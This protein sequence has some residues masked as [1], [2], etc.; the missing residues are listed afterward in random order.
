M[1]LFLGLGSFFSKS[2]AKFEKKFL[3]IFALTL[4]SM[5][6]FPFSLRQI[7]NPDLFLDGNQR[8][9]NDFHNSFGFPIF[10]FSFSVK[11]NFFFL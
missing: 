1:D 10:S 7:L 3:K 9:F 8:E 2:S 11:N 6:S 4:G 5:F